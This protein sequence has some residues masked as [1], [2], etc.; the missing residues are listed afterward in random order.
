MT[1]SMLKLSTAEA[2]HLAVAAS[3]GSG[4]FPD[5][6][7]V[8]R[9][10]G[11]LQLDPLARVA[12]A[13]RLTCLA[14]MSSDA[15]GTIIDEPL[16]SPGPARVFE[17]WVHAVC[18]V[19][20]D[21]WPLL[22]LV[23]DR[24]RASPRRPA[25][26][27]LREVRAIVAAWPDGAT[28]SDIERPG[29]ATRGWD[30]SERKRATEFLLRAGDLICSARRGARRVFDL[31]ERRVAPGLL[32]IRLDT[33]EILAT[34]ADR[35]LTAL[36]VATTRDVA[37]YYN[38]ALAD[39]QTGLAALGARPVSVATWSDPAWIAPA[40][41]EH[42]ALPREP[43]LIGPF[44]NLIWDRGRTR[45]VFDFDYVFEAYK[46]PARRKYGYY[47]LALLAD[48]TLRGR[49]DVRREDG[50]VRILAAYPEGSADPR[51]FASGLE[52]A[53]A[54]LEAQLA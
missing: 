4:P 26:A 49:A 32:D 38:L 25:E 46:P 48:G 24:V 28:I 12:R 17:T 11:L 29:L 43:V 47:V 34:C 30:W 52:A 51:R 18:L 3:L 45:R 5:G 50:S 16:W 9:H 31:P 27:A 53:V 2:R 42:R 23:R 39:A 15:R 33:D 10:L 44:D 37:G 36:G 21:D 54:R 20:V 14:R 1:P 40:H 22:R 19:P 7:A 6:L 35:A 41:R 13:H 8:L